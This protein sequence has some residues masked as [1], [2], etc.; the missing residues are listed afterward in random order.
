MFSFSALIS[1]NLQTREELRDALDSEIRTFASDCDLAGNALIA[2]NHHEFEVQYQC[3]A[4]E[5]RI[6]DY[7]LRLLLEKEDC[8]DSPI[9]RS[10]EFFND[11]Y[12]RFLLTTKPEMKC[13]CLQAMAI[14]YGR[15]HEDIGPFSDTKYIVGMLDR[16]SIPQVRCLTEFHDEELSYLCASP[17]LVVW[18]KQ[19]QDSQFVKSTKTCYT[20][21]NSRFCDV[22]V[23]CY[24]RSSSLSLS[25]LT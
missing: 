11:L 7:Y 17:S 20:H 13:M 3:L 6:G 16:V 24:M 9:R 10:Y 4:D 23:L 12:H 19:G 2:W 18:Q 1:G 14:V 22:N 8:P 5:V 25:I 21:I 15:H